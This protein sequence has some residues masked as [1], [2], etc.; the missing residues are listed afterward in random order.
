MDASEW[1]L[2]KV[3][4]DTS[5]VM[6]DTGPFFT[7]FV[8]SLSLFHGWKLNNGEFTKMVYDGTSEEASI[9]WEI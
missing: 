6:G 8:G 9:Y 3:M 2:V 1:K 7:M 5:Q 4:S